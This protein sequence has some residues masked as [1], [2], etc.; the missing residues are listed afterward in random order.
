MRTSPQ[1]IINANRLFTIE[2]ASAV[3]NSII[4]DVSTVMADFKDVV[5]CS[6]NVRGTFGSWGSRHRGV[7]R[8]YARAPHLGNW[9]TV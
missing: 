3:L 7:T 4:G 2:G 5:G 8:N 9:K 1:F 6:N